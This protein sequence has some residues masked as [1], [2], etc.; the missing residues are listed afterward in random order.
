MLACPDVQ[1]SPGF[2]VPLGGFFIQKTVIQ[3]RPRRAVSPHTAAGCSRL[4]RSSF[5]A[6]LVFRCASESWQPDRVR[7]CSARN[8]GSALARDSYYAELGRVLR[9]DQGVCSCVLIYPVLRSSSDGGEREEKE[10]EDGR[11]KYDRP[12][13]RSQVN[14][15]TSGDGREKEREEKGKESPP[16]TKVLEP[17]EFLGAAW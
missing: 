15:E 6:S 14:E 13:Q 17:S 12:L 10:E 5:L 1:D 3:V 8:L 4:G 7:S 11:S 9:V 16:P 2:H